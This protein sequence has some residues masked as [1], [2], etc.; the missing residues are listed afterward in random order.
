MESTTSELL[1]KESFVQISY[2]ELLNATDRFSSSNLIGASGFGF[3]YRG[4]LD[5]IGD[6]E[7]KVLNLVNPGATRSFIQEC[8]ALKNIRHRNLV[9]IVTCC[10]SIDF[11]GNEFKAIVYKLMMNE[12]LKKWLYPSQ[13]TS[14]SEFN[15]LQ[16]LR[17]AIDVAST[18][19]YLHY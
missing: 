6:V 17:V 16:R 3:V 19:D 10:S 4:A 14:R 9:K 11:Q 2:G 12:N 7:I 1:P 18:L 13:Q 8:K 15:L 5:Q